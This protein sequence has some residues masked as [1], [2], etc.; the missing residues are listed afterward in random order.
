MNRQFNEALYKYKD[1]NSTAMKFITEATNYIEHFQ[2]E[3]YEQ[4]TTVANPKKAVVS[5]QCDD[6]MAR[7]LPRFVQY[8]IIGGRFIGRDLN[9]RYSI[10]TCNLTFDKKR[11]QERNDFEVLTNLSMVADCDNFML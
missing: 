7:C 1:F 3:N 4:E 8:C 6:L 11:W 9:M 5:L 2:R 10:R